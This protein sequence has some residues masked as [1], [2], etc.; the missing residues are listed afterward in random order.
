MN[1][2]ESPIAFG[3]FIGHF[4]AKPV[5][6]I[7]VFSESP[8]F[9]KAPL[10]ARFNNKSTESPNHG[11]GNLKMEI[12]LKARTPYIDTLKSEGTRLA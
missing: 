3:Q 5:L 10:T 4:S 1:V 11:L 9:G 2:G 7:A 6:P 12:F 8:I